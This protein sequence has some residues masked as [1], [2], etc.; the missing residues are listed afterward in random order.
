MESKIAEAGFCQCG[1][2]KRTNIQK[3][4]DKR[5]SSEKGSYYKYVVGHRKKYS[6]HDRFFKFVKKTESCWEWIGA[7]NERGYGVFTKNRTNIKA[8]RF[9]WELVYGKINGGMFICHSCDNPSC[10]NPNHLFIGNQKDNMA[11]CKSKG[12]MRIPHHKGTKNGRAVLNESDVVEILA[13][14]KSGATYNYIAKKY[15][16]HV[17]TV[18][19]IVTRKTWKDIGERTP[20]WMQ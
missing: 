10:V 1:C 15:S 3:Y 12:R 20:E 9:S 2:G 16:V 8:H 5:G 4:K 14:R 6:D 19:K 18:A 11:D 7:K 17:N 13:L